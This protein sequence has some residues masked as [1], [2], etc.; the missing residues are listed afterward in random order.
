MREKNVTPLHGAQPE[1]A[2]R[3]SERRGVDLGVALLFAS[4]S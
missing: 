4:V 3:A 1:M 2:L